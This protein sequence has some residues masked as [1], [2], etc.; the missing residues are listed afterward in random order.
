MYRVMVY[1]PFV[2]VKWTAMKELAIFQKYR[3]I[4]GDWDAF[5][6]IHARPLPT[7]LW[8]NTLRIVS[9]EL[10]DILT[11]DNIP[12]EPLPWV[13]GGFKLASDFKPGRHWAFLAGLYQVQESSAMLPVLLLDP[14]P[15]ERVLDLCAAPGNKTAQIAV[16]MANRGTVVANDINYGRMRAVRQSL[17]RLGL[18]NVTTMTEDGANLPNSVG[19][20][21][22]V[23]VDVPCSCQ[24]TAR[25]DT[26]VARRPDADFV[27]RKTGLQR[28]LL[29]RAIELCQPGGRIVYAT[30]TYPPEENEAVVDTVLREYSERV[31]LVPARISGF[32]SSAGLVEWEDQFFDPSLAQTMRVWPQQ[33][34]TGAFFIAVLEKR[35]DGK[36]EGQRGG[37]VA[38]EID[39]NS[40]FVEIVSERF[41]ISAEQFQ[42]YHLFE[43]G[44]G[45]LYWVNRD[46][47][48][49]V[50]P[51]P[52]A[53][54]MLL[55]RTRVRYPKLTTAAAMLVGR[56]ATQ[57]YVDVNH[58]Q[59]QA[60]ISR[61][62]FAVSLEQARRCTGVGYVLIRHRGYV[63]GVGLF[64]P[65]ETGGEVQS[66]FPKGWSPVK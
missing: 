8:A 58:T 43:R 54:G 44:R 56:A 51:P 15:G 60:Y 28:A 49:P 63:L 53:S 62:N 65:R 42:R 47:Q 34:D 18:V 24:G 11:A 33:N 2:C 31:R 59:M 32:A 7:T 36:D 38:P 27:S 10:A 61:Q 30:C 35:G 19:S 13:P 26:A 1:W 22:R 9:K 21:D 23:L 16:K 5:C 66:M 14:Q 46:H 48:P 3:S 41:G 37:E 52:D 29:R 40:A 20:F 57:N 50:T 55:M 45:K 39:S 25:R 12:F 64:Y 17:E 6:A 4:L